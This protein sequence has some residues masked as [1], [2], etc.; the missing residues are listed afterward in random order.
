MFEQDIAL[1]LLQRMRSILC[2]RGYVVYCISAY[3][4]SIQTTLVRNIRAGSRLFRSSA[5]VSVTACPWYTPNVF[6]PLIPLMFLVD[7]HA[8]YRYSSLCNTHFSEHT[9]SDWDR[10]NQLGRPYTTG[11]FSPLGAR[12]SAQSHPPGCTPAFCRDRL[13]LKLQPHSTL[14]AHPLA[15]HTH[16]C[17][18]FLSPRTLASTSSDTQLAAASCGGDLHKSA[19]HHAPPRPV[20]P[21]ASAAPTAAQHSQQCRH[22]S[23][24][25]SR[26]LSP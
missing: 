3:L 26:S 11:V 25:I 2:S 23:P 7:K 19:Q 8:R 16:P 12:L 9:F 4:T 15:S 21:E 10:L 17:V 1:L 22:A 13:A 6:T 5:L 14:S 20:H 18:R 24:G